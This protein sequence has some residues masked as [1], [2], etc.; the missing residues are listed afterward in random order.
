MEIEKLKRRTIHRLKEIKAE[1]Q[2]SISQIMSMMEERGQF[3]SEA[4]LKKIFQDVKDADL[5]SVYDLDDVLYFIFYPDYY[6]NTDKLTDEYLAE[7]EQDRAEVLK[8]CAGQ[9]YSENRLKELYEGCRDESGYLSF[10]MLRKQIE[11]GE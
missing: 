8:N 10:E 1:Q 11:G 4:T 6:F 9:G 2:L 3:V 7:Y 5:T